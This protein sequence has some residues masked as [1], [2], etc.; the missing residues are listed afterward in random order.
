VLGGLELDPGPLALTDP[1]HHALLA[2]RHRE[3]VHGGARRGREHV[4]GVDRA[5]AVVLVALLHGHVRDD[6]DDVDLDARRE[7]RQAVEPRV[8]ALDE[9]VG[10]ERAVRGGLGRL[11]GAGVGGQQQQCE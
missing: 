7:Q 10:G 5:G 6:A 1:R 4:T 9:E 8:A 11:R 3:P 2:H